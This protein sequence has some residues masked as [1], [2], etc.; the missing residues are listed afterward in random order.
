MGNV[1]YVDGNGRIRLFWRVDGSCV[2]DVD[3]MLYREMN[4]KKVGMAR[5]N[6]RSRA[7]QSVVPT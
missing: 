3:G 6:A 2:G 5:G 7:C 1:R 4:R